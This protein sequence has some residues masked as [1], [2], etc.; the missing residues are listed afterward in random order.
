MNKSEE[1]IRVTV[2]S[3]FTGSI[4]EELLTIKKWLGTSY[5]TEA[6]KFCIHQ[7]YLGYK[8]GEMRI[9]QESKKQ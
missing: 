3:D 1:E 9:E 6:V 7:T 5:V 2:R 4:A 8:R